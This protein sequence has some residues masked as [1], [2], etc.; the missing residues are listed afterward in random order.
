MAALLSFG[1][2]A[3]I[4]AANQANQA[5]NSGS[6]QDD[7]AVR[8]ALQFVTRYEE[9]DL[10]DI[11][12]HELT[13]AFKSLMARDLFLQQGGFMRV[14]S[15]GR[16]RSREFVGMQPFRQTPTGQ[17]GDYRYVRFRTLHPNGLVF[18]DV[19]MDNVGG[20]WKVM[21]FYVLPAPQQ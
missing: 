18:Q 10:G 8:A 1:L 15:G 20:T 3:P 12:D 11:Y 6:P 17:T 16:A 4:S 7:P 9:G 19:Y 21:G 14:Q 5:E 13:T 2:P